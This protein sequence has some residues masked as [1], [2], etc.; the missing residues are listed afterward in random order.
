MGALD[1]MMERQRVYEAK[2][3]ACEHDFSLRSAH[4]DGRVRSKCAALES[5]ILRSA[6]SAAQREIA[7]LRAKLVSLHRRVQADEGD[8]ARAR[9]A[10]TRDGWRRE[11]ARVYLDKRRVCG[12]LRRRM[13]RVIELSRVPPDMVKLAE[14]AEWLRARS[15]ERGALMVEAIRQRDRLAAALDAVLGQDRT[16]PARDVVVGLAKSVDHLLRDHDCDT[17]GWEETQRCRDEAPRL[18]AALDTA[19]AVLAEI[20]R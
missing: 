13:K 18:L 12:M 3:S 2:V 20:R 7:E 17:H 4:G 8:I 10:E 1:E 14:E 11:I 15:D 16:W 5:A 6:L 19:I 9:L